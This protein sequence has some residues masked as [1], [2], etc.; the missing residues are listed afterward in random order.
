MN[1]NR[2]NEMHIIGLVHLP[3]EG[4]PTCDAERSNPNRPAAASHCYNCDSSPCAWDGYRKDT[5]LESTAGT[6]KTFVHPITVQEH[7]ALVIRGTVNALT[8]DEQHSMLMYLSG[9]TPEL[10]AEALKRI[11]R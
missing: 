4:C 1:N 10:F 8:P 9:R 2:A 6:C 7:E 3:Y 11:G 5:V